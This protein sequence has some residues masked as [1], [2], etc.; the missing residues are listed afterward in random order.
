MTGVDLDFDSDFDDLVKDQKI[1]GQK[2]SMPPEAGEK[3]QRMPSTQPI[4]LD[5]I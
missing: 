4:S 1:G 5:L 2:G 3:S